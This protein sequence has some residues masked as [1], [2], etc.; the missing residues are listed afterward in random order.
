[1]ESVMAYKFQWQRDLLRIQRRFM[2]GFPDL[3]SADD[4]EKMIQHVLDH[5]KKSYPGNFGL[6]WKYDIDCGLM[7]LT[8]VFERPEEETFWKLKYSN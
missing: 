1:M 8:P 7:I 5:F 6:R 3:T 2:G 4:N